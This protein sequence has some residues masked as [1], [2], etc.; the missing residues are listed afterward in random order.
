M[1]KKTCSVSFLVFF[2]CFML[3]VSWEQQKNNVALAAG[4]IPEESIRLR[5]LAHSD[6]PQD[7]WIKQKV[8]DAV[9]Q[10]M[11]TWVS[12]PST[13]EEAREVVSGKLPEIKRIIEDVLRTYQVSQSVQVELGEVHFPTKMYGGK[14]YPAGLYE[15]LRVT[16]GSGKGQ[17]WWCVLFPPLCFVDGESGEA[18]DADTA[19][20]E[21]GS[22]QT[23]SAEAG[24]GEETQMKFFLWEL[25][26]KLIHWIQNLFA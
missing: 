7:Q 25:L 18:A 15:A 26:V 12:G 11:N 10:Q 23:A 13:L 9:T 20:G 3:M 17:N 6:A 24:E 16:L 1:Q 22:V 2:I 4:E 14:V 8:R 19:A 5:I 21:D